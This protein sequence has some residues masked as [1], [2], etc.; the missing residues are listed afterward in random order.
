MKI[1]RP[2]GAVQNELRP[3]T[4]API[5]DPPKPQFCCPP[6]QCGQCPPKTRINEAV[7]IRPEWAE[8]T[9][10]FGDWGCTE[11]NVEAF[12]TCIELRIRK[13]GWCPVVYVAKP[14]KALLDGSAVFAWC[15]DLWLALGEGS[16]EADVFINGRSCLTIGLHVPV[17]RHRL[18]SVGHT[19]RMHHDVAGLYPVNPCGGDVPCLPPMIDPDGPPIEPEKC[20][21]C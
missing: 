18:L 21:V 11:F 10:R 9:L 4:L 6:P 8:T 7:T 19:E 14:Y 5:P 15:D 20:D 3:C 17:C 12:H 13:R 2:Q 1:I 16:F